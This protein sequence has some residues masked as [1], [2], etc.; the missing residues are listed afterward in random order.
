M[1]KPAFFDDMKY[2]GFTDDEI[3]DFDVFLRYLFSNLVVRAKRIQDKEGIFQI[4]INREK[5]TFKLEI[6]LD[7]NS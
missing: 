5:K 4:A 7:F 3:K 1:L 6:N 2:L